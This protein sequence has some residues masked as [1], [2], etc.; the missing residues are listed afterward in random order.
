MI[1]LNKLRSAFLFF[2]ILPLL[3]GSGSA[4]ESSA[5]QF[6]SLGFGARALGMGEAFTA[7]A[8]DVSA[9]YYNPAGLARLKSGAGEALISHSWHIQDTGLTQLAYARG[10]TGFSLTYFSAGSLEGRDEAGNLKSDFTAED[11]AFSGGYAVKAGKLSAGAALKAVRQRI[12]SSA[13]SAFCADAGLL[14][15]F[16]GTPV[17]LGLSVSNLGTEVKFEDESFPLPV[18]YRAGLAVRT[19]RAFPAVLAAEADFPNDSS[20]IFRIGLEYTGFEILALRAGY[21]TAPS[22]QRNAILGKGFGGSSG[23]NELYGFFMGLG[24]DLKSMKLDYA[25]LPYGELGS[26]HRF[27]VGMR[28]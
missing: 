5:A 9:V 24:F 27:S 4:A 1:N 8:D 23:L 11:F 19:G 20:A 17:T 22:S 2:G 14:Y 7:A 15:G 3:C 18:V 6:L 16:D 26:S 13:A 12:K 21:R 10:N 28:F 25:L